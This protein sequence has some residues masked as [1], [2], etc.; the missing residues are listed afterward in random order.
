MAMCVAAVVNKPYQRYLPAFVYFCVK[1]YPEY[2]VK[3]FLTEELLPKY[4]PML[5]ILKSLGDL[6]IVENMFAGFPKTNQELKTLRWII[7][8]EMFDGYDNIYMGDID[9]LMC[10]EPQAL[11]SQHIKHCEDTGLAYSNSVRPGSNRLSGLHFIRKDAYY[12]KMSLI[13]KK[14]TKKLIEGGLRNIKNEVTLYNMV[15]ASGLGF[16]KVW[17]RPHHGLHLGL[18]RK[19]PRK[20]EQRYW[21]SIDRAAY[22]GYYEYY[23]KLKNAG[24]PLFKEATNLKEVVFMEKILGKEFRRSR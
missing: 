9:I 24:D 1:S 13:T 8:P 3:I 12:A 7:K 4:K 2:G 17:F 15:K 11:E 10:K 23:L 22:K 20:I 18:W 19:G 21:D 6:D 16:P 14:Y 5:S